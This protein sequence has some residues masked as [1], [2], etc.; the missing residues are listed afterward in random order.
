M[1]QTKKEF[2][3]NL[4]KLEEHLFLL[5]RWIQL[6]AFLETTLPAPWLLSIIP[7]KLFLHIYYVS[8]LSHKAELMIHTQGENS[9]WYRLH[10]YADK[11]R[12]I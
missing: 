7:E 9:S 1:Q 10:A 12:G 8:T 3:M 2:S 5:C 6:L 4:K 11:L